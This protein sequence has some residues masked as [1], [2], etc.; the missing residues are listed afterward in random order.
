MVRSILAVLSG[1]VV[2]GLVCVP[3]NYLVV[4]AFPPRFDENWVTTHTGILI[5]L[6]SLTL[7]FA[8]TAGFV[9]A[10]IARRNVLP[11]LLALCV[12]QLAIGIAVQRQFWD[13][14]PLW[15]HLTFFV[16]VVVGTLLGGKLRR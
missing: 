1:P 6:V 16:L 2:Y 8:G 13:V 10:L 9:C 3:V 11:H 15:Y 4:A 12:L 7:L 5:L 14:L